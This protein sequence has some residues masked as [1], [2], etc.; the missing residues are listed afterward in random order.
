MVTG[1]SCLSLVSVSIVSFGYVR[2]SEP[3]LYIY[4]INFDY[5]NFC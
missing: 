5:G 4:Y 3:I 1:S 2:V